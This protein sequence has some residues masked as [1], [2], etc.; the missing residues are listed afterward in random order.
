MF[1]TKLD[2]AEINDECY[3]LVCKYALFFTDD[4]SSTLP[5]SVTN[6]LQKYSDVF[7]TKIPLGLPP[8]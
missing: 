2:L 5:P 1:A 4:I 8:I 7:P 3:A 6:L